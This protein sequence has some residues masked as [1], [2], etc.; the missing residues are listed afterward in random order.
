MK[1]P[2]NTLQF[3]CIVIAMV[4]AV[5]MIGVRAAEDVYS[6][7]TIEIARNLSCP[8]CEGQTIA[9]SHSRIAVEMVENVES[10]VQ[11]GRSDEEIYNYFRARFGDEV[12]VEPPREG[13][14]LALW[15]V[16]LGALLL[17]LVV[18]GLYFRDSTAI[19]RRATAANAETP[20]DRDLERL[21]DRVLGNP[22]TGST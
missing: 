19:G 17:G 7:R 12:L 2:H 15:W 1:R 14:N 13:I 5:G 10:Q 9:D 20:H 4:A 21:A 8:V 18:V 6:E 16:P 11:A 3:V 22:D